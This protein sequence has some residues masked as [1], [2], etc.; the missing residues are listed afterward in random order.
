MKT[1]S[2]PPRDLSPGFDQ[3]GFSFVFPDLLN[4]GN[5][6]YV[7]Q[8]VSDLSLTCSINYLEALKCS[9]TSVF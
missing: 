5:Q 3:V 9:N 6:V 1:V 7:P 2:A 8:L 4:L